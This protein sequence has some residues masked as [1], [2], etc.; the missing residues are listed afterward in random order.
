MAINCLSSY[1]CNSLLADSIKDNC[2]NPMFSGIDARA[3]IFNYDELVKSSSDLDEN[4]PRIINKFTFVSGAAPYFV[5]NARTNP[6]TGTSTSVEVGDLRNTFTRTVALYIPMDGAEASRNILDPMANG[7]FV[8][9]MRNNYVNDLQDN[10]FQVYGYDKGLVVSS[11][12]QTKYENNDYWMVEL[13]EAGVP[14]SGRFLQHNVETLVT[15]GALATA[16]LENPLQDRTYQLKAPMAGEL[17]VFT[18]SEDAVA[19][20]DVDRTFTF[21]GKTYHYTATI[22][23]I[24]DGS[25]VT[26]TIYEVETTA[27][28]F[29]SLVPE[30]LPILP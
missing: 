4:N 21:E 22:N 9:V 27:D 17:D 2:E 3:L 19:P 25:P 14:N 29:C 20:Y 10:E 6:F 12:T 7:R 8:V 18:V 5:I 26:P 13:Q 11:M 23:N 16:S 15:T 24:G 28:Y 30:Q 1:L